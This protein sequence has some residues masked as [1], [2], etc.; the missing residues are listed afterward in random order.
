VAEATL[1]CPACGFAK[2]E[3]MP[4]DTC[5]YFYRCDGCGEILKPLPGDCCVFCSY[6]DRQCPPKQARRP[7]P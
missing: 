7:T 3:A 6:S 4:E 2:A 1:T 5:L